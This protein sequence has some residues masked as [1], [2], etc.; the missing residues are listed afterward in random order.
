MYI[1]GEARGAEELTDEEK[2]YG[3]DY[4]S[5][6]RSTGRDPNSIKQYR[7]DFGTDIILPESYR[8]VISN[9]IDS[10][11]NKTFGFYGNSGKDQVAGHL[12]RINRDKNGNYI[13]SYSDIWDFEPGSYTKKWGDEDGFRTYVQSWLLDKVG[14]PF[15]VRSNKNIE[16]VPDDEF[17]DRLQEYGHDDYGH[18][19]NFYSRMTRDGIER[20]LSEKSKKEGENSSNSSPTFGDAF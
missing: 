19:K 2:G 16:F 9:M 11:N 14:T 13:M 12:G 8:D 15:I 3:V 6:I 17:Y 7:G 10:G 5:Y 18:F 4:S 1:Y 20:Y